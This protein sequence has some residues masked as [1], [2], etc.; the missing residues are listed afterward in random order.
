MFLRAVSG[1]LEP[2]IDGVKEKAKGTK[3]GG[4]AFQEAVLIPFRLHK[5]YAD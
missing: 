1:T 4:G 2:K 5:V 3:Y